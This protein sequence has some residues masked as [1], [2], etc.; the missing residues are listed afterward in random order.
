M[1]G[2][3]RN[4]GKDGKVWSYRTLNPEEIKEMVN[5]FPADMRSLFEEKLEGVDGRNVKDIAQLLHPDADIMP[6]LSE[7][8]GLEHQL[9][10]S[11]SQKN[12]AS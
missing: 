8:E 9:A 10:T 7:S 11:A 3:F 4:F 6:P 12:S 1:D 2:V 5:L